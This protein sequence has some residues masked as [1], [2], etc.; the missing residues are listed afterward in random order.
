MDLISSL[1]SRY[2]SVK[3]RLRGF[4]P[5]KALVLEGGGMRGIFLAGVLQ[6]FME[7]GYSPW[8]LIIGTSAGA[9][10]GTAYA[11]RQIHLARDAFFSELLTGRFIRMSNIFRPEKH[12]LNLDW[13]I[14][15]FIND[16][17]DSLDI[18]R[19]RRFSCPVLAVATCF[20]QHAPP[21]PVY[22][23]TKRDNIPQA[24]KASA[25]IPFLYRN[26]VPYKNELLMDGSV[27]DPLPFKKALELGFSEKD[28][29]VVTTRPKDYRKD[30]ESF[31]V[32]RLYESYYRDEQYQYLVEA[33]G[34]H[35]EM[36]NQLLDD[37]ESTSGIDVIYPP[38]DFKV[39]RLTRNEEKIVEGFEQGV[40]AARKYLYNEP[41]KQE[42][43]QAEQ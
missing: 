19:L 30:R 20:Y 11:A 1:L 29:L 18:R 24:L 31:W 37:M 16:H 36:Y 34:H 32:K 21:H 26:F 28:I 41:E 42:P 33:L 12:V 5:R 23:S 38:D 17:A 39:N 22:L 8:R 6:A 43:G 3:S 4:T 15:T 7:R 25:A 2:R 9:L 13:M 27:C 35:C 40:R 14:D 10:I